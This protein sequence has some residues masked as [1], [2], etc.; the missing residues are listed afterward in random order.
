M[1]YAD[2]T[3]PTFNQF[4]EVV[5]RTA[6]EGRSSY[7]VRYR[8]SIHSNS[9]PLVV[10]GYG[11]ELTL[12]RTDYIVID[13]REAEKLDKDGLESKREHVELEDTPVADLK[14]LS[15][16]ELSGLALKASSYAMSSEDPLGTLLKLS[17]DFPKHSSTILSHNVTA[18]FES[19]F[20]AN[21]KSLP[22]GH[23]MVW[24]NGVQLD[25]RQMD[26]FS[27]LEH[28]RR[29]R[30]LINGLRK[31]GLSGPEAVKLLSHP[32]VAASQADGEPQRFDFR[33]TLE[34]GQ[35]IIWLNN[36]EKDKRYEGWSTS[37][38]AVRVYCG[39]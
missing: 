11:V 17:Q 25:A 21:R 34:G 31:L 36:L 5:S 4:H 15:A 24:I 8:P 39:C 1:I 10:S 9:R 20:T 26:A 13:D 29:E 14:P 30:K 37:P 12:K 32:A 7:R 2:I 6:K 3:S 27:L 28:L 18:P 16:T 33:D 22:A 23:S 19:E 35:V 38:Q